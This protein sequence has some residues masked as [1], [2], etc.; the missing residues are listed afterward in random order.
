MRPSQYHLY[1]ILTLAGRLGCAVA[2]SGYR[3]T[4]ENGDG[5]RLQVEDKC[6]LS[7]C[8]GEEQWRTALSKVQF[9][10]ET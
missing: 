10:S 7:A 9:T 1:S 2:L 5:D 8:N 6:D 3:P 4:G